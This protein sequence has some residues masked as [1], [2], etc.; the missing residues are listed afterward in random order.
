[1]VE[2]PT[3]WDRELRQSGSTAVVVLVDEKSV[4]LCLKTIAKLHR[5][6]E[7]SSSK[8]KAEDG[9]LWP[10]WGSNVPAIATGSVRYS[11]HNKLR[12]PSP[13]ELQQNVDLYIT[14]FNAKEDEKREGDKRRRNEPDED[15]FVTVSR[16]GRVGPARAE[17]VERK[18]VEMEEKERRKREEL[19]DFYRFQMRER[20]K[21]QQGEMVRRFEED[22]RKVEELKGRRRGIF[23][24]EK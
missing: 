14:A 24:P 18:R 1:M 20:R 6:A 15:G 13:Q 3:T 2:L 7:K 8:K 4:E 16:G 9:N 19:G 11:L 21:E 22:R 5:K 10:V 12:F 17:E 23:V